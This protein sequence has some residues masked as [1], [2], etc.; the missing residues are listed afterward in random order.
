[1]SWVDAADYAEAEPDPLAAAAA[2]II[3]H[4]NGDHAEAQVLFCRHL[5]ERPDTTEARTDRCTPTMRWSDQ[6]PSQLHDAPLSQ[7][8]AAAELLQGSERV[9]PGAGLAV[10]PFDATSRNGR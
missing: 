5:A 10:R 3:E 2:G 1:M 8:G 7:G 4:M 6:R 9:Q